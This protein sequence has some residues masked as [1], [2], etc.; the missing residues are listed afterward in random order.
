MAR[1]PENRDDLILRTKLHR[2]P[3][4][5]DLVTRTRLHERMDLGQETPLTLISA[6]AGYGKSMLVSQWVETSEEPCAWLS[7][8]ADDS[9][10]ATFVSYL[11]ASVR[12]LFPDACS[13]TESLI[14]AP[15]QP[16]M[17]VLGGHLV[18]ELDAV[19]TAFTLALDNYQRIAPT[20]EAHELLRLLLE[21]PPLPL[22][23]VPPLRCR[24]PARSARPP[25]PRC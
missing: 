10:L 18:N 6:P 11:L 8:D 14:T 2:P 15:E 17:Q 20:S 13:Q 24:R 5:E 25:R 1:A 7:L 4:T 22:R 23:L 9:D 21:H 19:D 16:A 12:T 3:V